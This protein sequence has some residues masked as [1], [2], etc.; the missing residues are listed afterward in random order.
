MRTDWQI[1]GLVGV[2]WGRWKDDETYKQNYDHDG[3]G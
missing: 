2:G 1:D 3:G